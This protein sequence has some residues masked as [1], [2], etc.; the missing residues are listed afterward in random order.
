MVTI[1]EMTNAFS[2]ILTLC[3][4]IFYFLMGFAPNGP[5]VRKTGNFQQGETQMIKCIQYA[6]QRSLVGQPALQR[7]YGRGDGDNLQASQTVDPAFGHDTPHFDS[8]NSR[9]IQDSTPMR[10]KLVEVVMKRASLEKF[11]L[12]SEPSSRFS[13]FPPLR[14]C[15]LYR[16]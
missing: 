13:I 14:T 16:C 1:F 12:A 4:S 8:V 10:K 3:F 6:A 2:I 9:S 15:I 11:G 7:R 5:S